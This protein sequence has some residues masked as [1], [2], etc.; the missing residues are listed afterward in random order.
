[1]AVNEERQEIFRDHFEECL[2]H[3][4]KLFNSKFPS[5]KRGRMIHA[6]PL[7]EFCGVTEDTAQRWLSVSGLNGSPVGEVL[8]RLTCYLDLHGYRIIEFERLPKVVRNFMELIGF[9]VLSAD[10][11]TQLLDYHQNSEIYSVFRDEKNLGKDKENKMWEVWKSRRKELENK[12]GEVFKSSRL[13]FISKQGASTQIEQQ[14][15]AMSEPAGSV[16]SRRSATLYIMRG[17]LTLLDEGLFNNLS[18]SEME[19][20]DP[21]DFRC[22]GEL[23]VRFSTISSKL[24][25]VKK[26]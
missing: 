9:G 10:K 24:M 16:S 8:I 4:A 15:L 1:M 25:R 14:V 23:S 20:L 5:R 22:I 19:D 18:E 3:F 2:T 6:K 21:A 13:E 17:L 26:E 7:I 12:K 11:A